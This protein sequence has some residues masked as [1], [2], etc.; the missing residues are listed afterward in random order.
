M[1]QQ[2]KIRCSAI[3]KIMS[4]P[5]GKSNLQKYN[6]QLDKVEGLKKRLTELKPTTKTY[7]KIEKIKLPEALEELNELEKVKHDVNLSETCKK[8]LHEWIIGVKY[9][10]YPEEINSRATKKGNGT[11]QAGFELIRDVYFPSNTLIKNKKRYCNDFFTGE[12]DTIAN[13]IVI[14]NKSS[15]TIF[16]FPFDE[17]KLK[18][19]YYYQ[20]QGYMNLL[21]LNNAI[22]A[23]TLNE[24][25]YDEI[26]KMIYIKDLNLPDE[27]KMKSQDIYEF[28]KL[29][30]Y[31]KDSLS[32]FQPLIDGAD[33]SDFVEIPK[34]KRIK[35]F[36]VDYDIDVIT[37]IQKRVLECRKY[38][39]KIFDL[40]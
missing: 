16:T 21:N 5:V 18:K 28:I 37:S 1:Q 9:G 15:W 2:F 11:E 40:F 10:R 17:Q 38:I 26:A 35:C 7:Q 36:Y 30:I 27:K 20:V 31:T 6:E 22:V 39:D 25:D 12:Y 23:Y 24:T 19:D 29:H 34:E 8:H 13:D 3:G 33:T 32:K 4:E 14:D